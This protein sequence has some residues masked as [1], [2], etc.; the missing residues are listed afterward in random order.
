MKR[1]KAVSL[2]IFTIATSLILSTPLHQAYAKGNDIKIVGNQGTVSSDVSPYAVKGTTLV[3]VNVITKL[4]I[5]GVKINWNNTN[6][7]ITIVHNNETITLKLNNSTAYK[8][9]TKFELEQPAILKHGRVMVPLR[10]IGEATGQKVIWDAKA[11]TILI[12]EPSSTSS[13]TVTQKTALSKAREETTNL[14]ATAL[15][16]ELSTGGIATRIVYFPVG[17][18]DRYFEQTI[19]RIT[20]YE[21]KNG[22]RQEKWSANFDENK[23]AKNTGLSFLPF[24]ITKELGSRPTIDGAVDYY[25]FIAPIDDLS[26]GVIDKQGKEKKLG[27]VDI[28]KSTTPFPDINK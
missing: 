18:S 28:S 15:G 10:F 20:Y 22:K 1:K 23:S 2:I 9:G 13:S 25:K 12:G 26:Y 11:R 16:D 7:E 17:I 6:K 8:N 24:K 3:P 5:Q 14:P 4:N 19:G 21:V 27:H